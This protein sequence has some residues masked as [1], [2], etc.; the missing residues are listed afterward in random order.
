MYGLTLSHEY[1]DIIKDCWNVYHDWMTV[2]L[3]EPKLFLPRP[4][5]DDALIYSKKMLWHLYYLF[6]PRKE[7]NGNN[8]FGVVFFF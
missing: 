2:L 4:I 1:Q 5:K 3:D 8:G 6:V 7:T